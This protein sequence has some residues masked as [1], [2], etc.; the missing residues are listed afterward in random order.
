MNEETKT[1]LLGSIEKWKDIEDGIK[2]DH[3]PNNC[4]LCRVFR[5]REGCVFC[6][7][8][9][10]TGRDCCAES[11]YGEWTKHQ[12]SVHEEESLIAVRVYCSTCVELA[13]EERVFLE[14]L[15]V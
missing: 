5:L 14:S 11:P 13:K 10:R 1:A 15:L 8:R 9:E 3:G 6:P 2:E 7:V 12:F 4:P